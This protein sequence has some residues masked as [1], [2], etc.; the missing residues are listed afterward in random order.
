MPHICSQIKCSC[1]CNY[2]PKCHNGCP[3]CEFGKRR[4]VNTSTKSIE[5]VDGAVIF[6]PKN[7]KEI[8]KKINFMS[9]PKKVEFEK[10]RMAA[11]PLIKYL[12]ENHHPHVTAIVTSTS[13]ELVEGLMNIPNIFDHVKD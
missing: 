11:M 13:V 8:T 2:C 7:Y 6:L 12:N 10:L 5:I 4:V 3:Q 1:E 9:K